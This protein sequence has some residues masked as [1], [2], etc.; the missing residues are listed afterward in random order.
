VDVYAYLI[1]SSIL[2]SRFVLVTSL[3]SS[4]HSSFVGASIPMLP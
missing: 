1:A 3:K 2:E 4:K